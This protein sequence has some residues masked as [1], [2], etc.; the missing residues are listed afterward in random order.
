MRA[1]R[2]PIDA[3]SSCKI[4]SCSFKFPSMELIYVQ[5]NYIFYLSISPTLTQVLWIMINVIAFELQPSSEFW[6]LIFHERYDHQSPICEALRLSKRAD[7]I[8]ILTKG[9]VCNPLILHKRVRLLFPI[10]R[11]L[12]VSKPTVALALNVFWIPRWFVTVFDYLLLLIFSFDIRS[13]SVRMSFL[14]SSSVP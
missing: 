6:L 13:V 14:L 9:N 7:K 1:S 2:K 5:E 4:L 10:S 11:G 12:K 3:S 8:L